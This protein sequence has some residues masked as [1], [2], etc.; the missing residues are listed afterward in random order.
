M[1]RLIFLNH[2]AKTSLSE[3]HGKDDTSYHSAL[4]R[5]V[6]YLYSWAPMD[7]A[8]QGALAFA[9]GSRH[10]ALGECTPRGRRVLVL[11]AP[12]VVQHTEA[13][14]N[15][16]DILWDYVLLPRRLASRPYRPP[17]LDQRGLER[18]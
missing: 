18:T 16:T 17:T 2:M 11:Q 4:T 8:L 12:Q 3:E 7:P 14:H 6:V 1:H 13:P 10:T 9:Y 15:A 5:L